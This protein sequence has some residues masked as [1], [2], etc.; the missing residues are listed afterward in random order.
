MNLDVGVGSVLGHILA[1]DFLRNT[2]VNVR[3]WK[4]SGVNVYFPLHWSYHP[5]GT[6]YLLSSVSY[7][8]EIKIWDM[9]VQDGH[10]MIWYISDRFEVSQIDPRIPYKSWMTSGWSVANMYLEA[11]ASYPRWRR[12]RFVHCPPHLDPV[13]QIVSKRLHFL[14]QVLCHTIILDSYAWG[15]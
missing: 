7:H 10:G 14:Y 12:K 13:Y 1:F 11:Q 15:I 2:Y 4:H 6:L 3:G 8:P 9:M 5:I